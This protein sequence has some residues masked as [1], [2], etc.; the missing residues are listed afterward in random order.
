MRRSELWQIYQAL[1]ETYG[2]LDWW[3]ANTAYEVMVGAV[4]TQNTAWTNVEKAIGNFEGDLTP[5]RIQT[6]PQEELEVLIKPAGFFRQKT[7]YLKNLTSWYASYHFDPEAVQKEP[8]DKLREEL[9]DLKGIGPETADAILLYAFEFPTFVVDAYTKRLFSRY[10]LEAGKTYKEIKAYVEQR[11]PRDVKVYNR[12]HALIV[13]HAKAH[14]KKKPVCEGCP[15]RAS[16]ATG[17]DPFYSE[18]NRADLARRI[19]DAKLGR[20]MHEHELE[21]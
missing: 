15:L 20:N 11:L 18:E 19:A 12:L 4:L 2:E 17:I 5:H 1:R 7:L 10:P 13:H 14:C 16:C 6:L 21:S 3:P 9:L 8:I